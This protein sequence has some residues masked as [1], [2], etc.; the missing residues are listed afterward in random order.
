MASSNPYPFASPY[1]KNG[2]QPV[3]YARQQQQNPF[4]P[5]SPFSSSS[6]LSSPSEKHGYYSQPANS[7]ST[8]S[9]LPASS[10]GPGFQAAF[11]KGPPQLR[12][13]ASTGSLVRIIPI[14]SLAVN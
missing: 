3:Q 10:K 14:F 1:S 11:A 6:T 13:M 7:S 4:S 2:Q 12:S 5:V 8:A 9:L